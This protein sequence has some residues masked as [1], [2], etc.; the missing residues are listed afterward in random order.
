M[1]Q[2]TRKGM[3]LVEIMIVA[4]V[5]GVISAMSL[6]FFTE[7][8]K[9]TFVSEQKNLIN[10][11]IR[12]L[13][14]K[15]S[16]A[17]RQANFVILYESFAEDDRDDRGDRLLNG[18]AGDFIVFGFQ[19]E[20][21][22]D[23]AVNAPQPT[24]RL[25][26]YYR[27]PGNPSDPDSMGP[28]RMFDTDLDY[29]P[30]ESGESVL[31]AENPLEPP[32]P[33]ELLEDLYPESTLGSNREVV[34]MSEGLADKRLFYNFGKGTIMVNGKIVHGVEAKRVTDTYNFTIST[35]R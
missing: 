24:T 28:V 17:A 35:R 5:L 6:G 4:G 32:S 11:D 1:H 21:D 16:E 20:A 25:V 7:S 29:P 31:D 18:N 22:L 19:G 12:H 10:R 3:S 14:A 2:N 8:I 33:E 30:D 27:A 13:T 26:G 9:A 15:L 34:E 23:A